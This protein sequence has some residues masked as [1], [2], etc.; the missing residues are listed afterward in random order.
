MNGAC[1]IGAYFVRLRAAAWTL[2]AQRI[3][4]R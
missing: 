4:L 3:V 1:A 2:P